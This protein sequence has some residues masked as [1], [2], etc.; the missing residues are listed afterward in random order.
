MTP[1]TTPRHN[2]SNKREE[3]GVSARQKEE[4]FVSSEPERP[5]QKVF[6]TVIQTTVPLMLQGRKE[7]TSLPNLSK[8]LINS[9]NK[10]RIRS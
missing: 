6:V 8:P 4:N 3:E 9:F 5:E 1:P 10:S 7:K 2:Q